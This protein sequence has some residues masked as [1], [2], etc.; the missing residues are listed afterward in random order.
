[1]ERYSSNLTLFHVIFLPVFWWAFFGITV[2]VLYVGP[3]ISSNIFSNEFSK[4]LSLGLLIAGSLFFIFFSLRLKR[5]EANDQEV[6]VSNYFTNILMP[7]ENLERVEIIDLYIMRIVRIYL[8][9][10][11]RFGKKLLVLER[12]NLWQDYCLTQGIP[13]KVNGKNLN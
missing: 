7:V 6:Y 13:I 8:K 5:L 3:L 1:M 10:K 11:G 2:F 4:V 9:Q 12:E